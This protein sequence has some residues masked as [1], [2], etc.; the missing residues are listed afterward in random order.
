MAFS[1]AR[2]DADS[3]DGGWSNQAG[4][5]TN[6]YAS[7]DE[8]IADDADYISSSPG[9]NNDI[10]KL[11]LSD[12]SSV[13][14]PTTV[15]YRYKKNAGG[16][17]APVNMQ[18]SLL[19]GST[20]IASWQHD[21]IA[22]SYTLA[23]QSL[24][25]G[26]FSAIS[27]L[28]NLFLQFQTTWW[29]TDA[30][31]DLWFVNGKYYDSSDPTVAVTDFLSCS[32]ASV[33]Y[34]KNADGTL[35]SFA[36]DAL[37]ITTNGL[38]VEDART[39]D[40]NNSN[41]PGDDTTNWANAGIVDTQNNAVAPDG[42]TTAALLTDTATG[43]TA[44]VTQHDGRTGAGPDTFSVFVKSGTKNHCF[45]N[46]GGGA[47]DNW[48]AVA[49]DLSNGTV[50]DNAIGAGAGITYNTATIEAFTNGWYRISITA[51]VPL[52]YVT[53]GLCNASTG[54]TFGSFG[55]INYTGDGTGT[56]YVWGPQIENGASFPSSYVPTSTAAATR[57]AD[58]VTFD[59]N[60]QSMFQGSVSASV[61]VDLI[62]PI[63]PNENW[64]IIRADYDFDNVY[65]A[66]LVCNVG[67]NT[68][69]GSYTNSGNHQLNATLGNSRTMS[70][71]VKIG[72]SYQTAVG[73]S[74]VGGGGTVATDAFPSVVSPNGPWLGYGS[75]TFAYFRRLTVW[76]TRLA[77]ATLQALTAP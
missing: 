12:V 18:A 13:S 55:L 57:A 34:A 22:T 67:D 7:I 77:D 14:N 38:L 45:I 9:N 19:Q 41:V 5:Q 68:S 37:R 52:G 44:F 43:P 72:Y 54:V 29:L 63:T 1:Y 25:S 17:P 71:G 53:V 36:N 32:R 16:D 75:G 35:P 60:L 73:R 15:R 69:V 23:E 30:S 28:T 42:T 66:I 48:A 24:T 3:A 27:D 74:V 76:N 56:L 31:V 20:V 51:T 11:S 61:V 59:G 39:N 26:Q 40:C 70:G 58:V 64:R 10:V 8:T 49:F 2:P 65:E 21:D 6:L 46:L 50:G 62:T 33:G 4:S 47:F